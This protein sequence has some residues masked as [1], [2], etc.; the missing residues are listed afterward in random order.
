MKRRAFIAT[1]AAALALPSVVRAQKQS[2][3]KFIPQIDLSFLDPHWTTAYVTRNHGYLV[4]DT[5][6][7][8]DGSFKVSPQMVEGHAVEDDGKLWKLKLRD[9]LLWHDGERVLA[10]DCVASIKRWARRDAFG[11]TLMA[12]TDELSAPDDKTIQFRLKQPFPL[13]PMALGKSP[14]PM[15]AMM[16]ERL[17][18]TD[19]FKQI[20]EIV[21]SGPFRYVMSERVQGSRNVYERFDKYKPREGGTPDW[22]AGPKIVHFDRVE[23]TTIPDAATAAAA[24]QNG[25]QDW[26]EYL[27]HDL[28]PLMRKNPKI[29]VGVQDPTGGVEMMRTNCLQPPFNNPAIRRALLWAFD[30]AEFM[31][32]I[33]GDDPEMYYTPLGSFTPH[34]P[35]ASD[36]GLEPMQ[37]KRDYAK[38]R[39]MLK[40][41]GYA[42]E[43]VVLMVP[44]DYPTLKALGDVA[45]DTMRRVGMNVDYVVTD[46]GSMLQRRNKK[47][48]VEQ[49]G[50]SAFV[51]GWAGTDHLN[52]SGH[53]ALRGNGD[54]PSA[55][56]GWCVSPKLEALRN[57]WFAAPD[58]A[59]QQK[60]C[61]EMQR[62]AMI[63]VPYM[64]LGQYIQPTAYRADL[65][66]VLNGFATFWNLRRT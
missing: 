9:G 16:P 58:L 25:E 21:G 62:Q 63:D 28:M 31:Q 54:A 41:A 35:M 15:C 61:Q 55:W 47:D 36:V 17:A 18:N 64:P 59:A 20:T 12:T 34:T 42:G 45:A 32:A 1:S 26:W 8:Q 23:W 52:P 46:W 7:G 50:W 30:Q 33:V 60:V 19:P 37:G 29:K 14:S 53:I 22:T 51:T 43:K 49:G 4:F 66:G 57:A 13:L 39:Q 24:L 56:P 5:L 2:T 40:E 65:N 10:R 3:L 27:T 48:P 11:D 44:S 6:Y 38:V